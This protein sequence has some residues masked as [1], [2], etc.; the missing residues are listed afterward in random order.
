MALDL[1]TH[2]IPGYI[3]DTGVFIWYE[4]TMKGIIKLESS[5]KTQHKQDSDNYCLD[6]FADTLYGNIWYYGWPSWIC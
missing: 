5:T 6:N 1:F 2:I 3:T 4:E